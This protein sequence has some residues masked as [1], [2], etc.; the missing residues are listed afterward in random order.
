MGMSSG[1]A[2]AYLRSED[3]HSS[4]ESMPSKKKS[5]PITLEKLPVAERLRVSNASPDGV[6]R[7][8]FLMITCGTKTTPIEGR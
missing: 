5:R 8:L 4:S 1:V 7:K 3:T 6:C 2:T